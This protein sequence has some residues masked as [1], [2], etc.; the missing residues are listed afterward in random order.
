MSE[1]L[2]LFYAEQT[3]QVHEET[4]KDYEKQYADYH[5]RHSN[6]VR[7]WAQLE[8]VELMLPAERPSTKEEA[9]VVYDLTVSYGAIQ[10]RFAQVE[11]LAQLEATYAEGGYKRAMVVMATGLG[12]TYLA[13][14]FARKFKRV[15]FIVHREEIL[16]QA[17]QSF[18]QVL[19]DKT[20]G[21]Y[22]G[23]A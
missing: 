7:Q 14:F 4:L 3:V 5:Q 19:S 21:I 23:K 13:A 9:E 20:F 11:A 1:F 8:E 12:K 2:S 17:K 22:D 18:A 16:H 10:P 6:L 15:L